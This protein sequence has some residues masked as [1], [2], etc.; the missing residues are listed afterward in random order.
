MTPAGTAAKAFVS[1]HN[2]LYMDMHVLV[3][4]ELDCKVQHG[5]HSSLG[6]QQKYLTL[7]HGMFSH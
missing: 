5:N 1:H 3:A 4:P 7:S 6:I 2:D